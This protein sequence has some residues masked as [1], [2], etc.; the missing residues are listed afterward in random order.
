MIC[1]LT[2]V[3]YFRTS[4]ETF[5]CCNGTIK[6]AKQ[7]VY[8]VAVKIGEWT[9]NCKIFF[10]DDAQ[11]H[12]HREEH[13]AVFQK[14]AGRSLK[15]DNHFLPKEGAPRDSVPRLYL[16]FF[17]E[18]ALQ[19]LALGP[20]EEPEEIVELHREP[21]SADGPSVHLW[22]LPVPIACQKKDAENL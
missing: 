10:P 16:E 19:E 12:R 1:L 14:T 18:H 7:T 22:T 13:G 17:H 2:P 8:N 5:P 4:K 20:G 6:S 3:S 21:P 15:S 9:W 11:L